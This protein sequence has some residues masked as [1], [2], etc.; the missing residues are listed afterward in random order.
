M[1]DTEMLRYLTQ[2]G[3]AGVLAVLVLSFL[4]GWIV[5][6]YIVLQKD[7]ELSLLRVSVNELQKELREQIRINAQAA[8][9]AE[10]IREVAKQVI[11]E[12]RRR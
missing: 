9:V 8:T 7:Q 10:K 5:P 3:V 6:G 4:R 11:S 1:P 2:A 12:T